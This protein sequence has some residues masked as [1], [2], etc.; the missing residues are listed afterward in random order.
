MTTAWQAVHRHIRKVDMRRNLENA[1]HA[2][3]KAVDV[4]GMA[5]P[6]KSPHLSGVANSLK[7]IR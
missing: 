2:A 6:L 1:M 3:H 4:C 7:G 5:L